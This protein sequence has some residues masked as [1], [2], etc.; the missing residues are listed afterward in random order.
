MYS[1]PEYGYLRDTRWVGTEKVDGTNIRVMYEDG[2]VVLGGKTDKAQLHKDLVARLEEL[3]P[4]DLLAALFTDDVCLYGEG[5]GAGI[6]K[7]GGLYR[8]K[9]DFIL[10]DVRIGDWWLGREDVEVIACKLKIGV[11]PVVMSG[12]LG[13]LVEFVRGGFPSAVANSP[14]DAEGIVARPAVELHAR[15]GQ[16]II[17]KIKCGDFPE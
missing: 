9:K 4:C 5:F 13:M 6:Q 17:T 7:G 11:V 14:R 16:R 3:F 1:R 12:T 10:F 8:R 15:N 2:E